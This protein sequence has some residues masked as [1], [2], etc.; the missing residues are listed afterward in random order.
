[1]KCRVVQ[2]WN[3]G[4]LM[5]E[6]PLPLNQRSLRQNVLLSVRNTEMGRNQLY[7]SV[8]L[9]QITSYLNDLCIL[10]FFQSAKTAEMNFEILN[11]FMLLFPEA[12]NGYPLP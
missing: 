1:M 2:T 5:R 10:S 12:F 8:I 11:L 9:V 7:H 6:R 3:L 4:T